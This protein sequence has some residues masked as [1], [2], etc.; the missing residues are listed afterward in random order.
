MSISEILPRHRGPVE[1][2]E[3]NIGLQTHGVF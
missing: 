3:V 1:Y 2:V